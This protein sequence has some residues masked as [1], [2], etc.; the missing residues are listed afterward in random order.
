[1]DG[2]LPNIETS[3]SP[4]D[5]QARAD[6][7][8]RR[9]AEG[10][11][12]VSW[13]KSTFDDCRTTIAIPRESSELCRTYYDG[14]GQLT[15][16]L[17]AILRDRRQPEIYTNRIRPAVDGIV[18]VLDSNR[19][20]PRAYPREPDAE[21]SADIASDVLRYIK[22]MN[23]FDIIK[24][25]CFENGLV[26][27]CYAAIIEVD[28][29]KDVTVNQVR[30]D[31][32][33][34]DPH[35][36]RDDF[37]DANYLGVAKWM[38][39]DTLAATYPEKADE[40]NQFVTS[41]DVSAFGFGDITW[42]DKP[43]LSADGTT[44]SIGMWADPGKRRLMVVEM[45]Y[46]RGGKWYRILFCAAGEIEFG[47]SPYTNDKKSSIPAIVAGSC[48][49][50]GLNNT[51]YG[52]VRDMVPIQDEINMRRQKA[53]H[54]LNVRQV[55]QVDPNAP[56]VDVDTVRKEAARADGVLPPGWQ[57]VPHNDQIEGQLQLLQESKAELDRMSPNPALL[58]RGSAESSGRALQIRQ[59][60]GLVEFQRPVGR[61]VDWERR[62]YANM[63]Y[64]ARQFWPDDKY[65]R[66]THEDEAPQ[67]VRINATVEPGIP[68]IDPQTGQQARDPQ[69][70]PMW[71]T[72][73]KKENHI[74]QM[75]VDIEID[76]V[77]DTA[78]LQQ[79][80][81]NELVGLAKS[82]PQI[83]QDLTPELLVE[84]SPLPRKRELLE[85]MKK[86]AQE[87]QQAQQGQK[88]AVEQAA[89]MKLQAEIAKTE[90]ETV[91]NFAQAKN[92]QITGIAA[93]IQAHMTA[94]DAERISEQYAL[95]TPEQQANM[96]G[97]APQVAA[98]VQPDGQNG[99][100]SA[101]M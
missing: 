39:A 87:R 77:P 7:E 11:Q 73:P 34:Y 54:L 37:H 78:S 98:S 59:Q 9:V 10:Q 6:E 31:E 60:A 97:V 83:A 38:Y 85:K 66:V 70:N 48:Y 26:E 1:M 65:I 40:F 32:F 41:G 5:E 93:A 57:I 92:Y 20:D 84:I 100:A 101:P 16:T 29:D 45:Y 21:D 69:G 51:R 71:L 22:D 8:G 67:F 17:K 76:T 72:P 68:R 33:F 94:E 75:G 88:Q 90:S 62:C 96:A 64:R 4:E 52:I 55:Q 36:R 91:K 3:L 27:G 35:S 12:R 80:V 95:G 2:P 24:A 56:P 43:L 49:V 30:W 58:G 50:S 74:A 13:A 19:T 99:G 46:T 81:W 61:F 82:D 15:P 89:S 42:Q 63:W 79:E 23:H 47:E 18:G 44:G 53:L 28:A 25:N 86:N 14:P